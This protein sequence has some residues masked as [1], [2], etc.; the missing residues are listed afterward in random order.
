VHIR[1]LIPASSVDPV[2]QSCNRIAVVTLHCV[3]RFAIPMV[4][5]VLFCLFVCPSSWG[6]SDSVLTYHFDDTRSGQITDETILVP[7]N[8]NPTKFGKLFSYN[9]DGYVV[10]Q[11]LYVPNVNIPGQ[12]T[13]NVVYVVTMHDSVFA[14][15]ADNAGTGAPLWT[16]NFTNPAAG[17][18]TVPVATQGCTF[19]GFAEIGIMGTPVIDPSTGTLYL[20]AKTQVAVTPA[21]NPPTY[22]YYHTIH[23]LDITTGTEKFNGPMVV[24]ASVVNSLGQTINFQT[25]ALP[26]CQRPGLLLL[27]RT[28]YIAYGSNGCDLNSHGWVMG[29]NASNLQQQV[30]VFDT[31]PTPNPNLDTGSS[32]WMSGSGIAADGNG[33]LYISTANGPFDG[34]GNWGDSI[35]KL[36]INNDALTVTDS[37]TPFDQNYMAIHDLDLGSGGVAL[38]PDQPGIYPHLMVTSGKTGNVYL[39]N[40][41]DMGRYNPT[42]NPPLNDNT[43]IVQYLPAALGN[44][45]SVPVYWSGNSYV[46]FAAHNDAIKAFKLVNGMFS[47]A[48]P[49]AQSIKYAQ[50]GIP[51]IS[52]NGSEDGILWNIHNT[53]TPLLSAL[54][55]NTLVELYNS[56]QK[57]TRDTLGMV[58]NFVTPAIANN[59]VF[60]GA[61]GHLAV[62][63]VFPFLALLGGS[64]QS[65]TVGTAL[66][67]PL[68]VQAVDSQG[69]G[70]PGVTVNFTASVAGGTFN[71]PSAITDSNGTA[72]TTYTVPTKM[73]SIGVTASSTST[74]PAYRNVLLSATATAGPA[75]V[76]AK[77]T[78]VG[79]FGTA[80]TTLPLPLVMYLRDKYGNGVVGQPISFTD[81]GAGGTFSSNTI[82]TG[83]AGVASVSYTLPKKAGYIL[84][85]ASNGVIS[86]GAAEHSVAGPA[87]AVNVVAGN[88]QSAATSTKLKSLLVVSVTDQYGNVIPGV[89]VAFSDGG[90]GGTFSNPTY[91]TNNGGQA[92][93]NYTTPPQAQLVHIKAT[94]SGLPAA[95]FTETVTSK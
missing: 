60:V 90:V 6:Q 65:A 67:Q 35:L 83:A 15:D 82:I 43:N 92:N 28:V 88:N 20:S 51:V 42:N 41:D 63:G 47:P 91:T 17:I 61:E 25:A 74:A 7:S 30:A 79:Q 66:S 81:G 89:S 21:T 70:D 27:N 59:K 55:A 75:T 57:G 44:F 64:G 78:G 12:G 1:A 24:N 18:T 84:I 13:H 23:A 62:Y 50:V 69:N 26:Q 3:R 33:S 86:T 2:T 11:P 31:A 8:V 38:L 87:A 94:V 32:L 29:Y 16:V 52:S 95:A 40:R 48:T 22:N 56:G 53:T 80:G 85:T 34:I 45:K 14:F 58:N 19:T 4:A 77:T 46:Y 72:T 73:G 93:T 5:F 71:P 49:I 36:G 9:V 37:F 10:A 68:T 39:V 54:D 76:I